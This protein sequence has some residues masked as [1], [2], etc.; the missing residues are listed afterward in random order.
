MMKQ[1]KILITVILCAFVMTLGFSQRNASGNE[2]PDFELEL[3]NGKTVR[4]SD[5]K[6]KAVLLH[7]WATWC[8]P[9]RR[10]LPEMNALAEKLEQTGNS[11]LVFLAVCVSDTE[12]NRASF[13]KQNGYTFTNG[14]D[15]A[16]TIAGKYNIS[17][18]PTSVLI[19]PSGEIEKINVGAMSKDKIDSFVKGYAD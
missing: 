9:C 14:L 2:A 13:M 11:K 1:K 16:G 6:G 10:E 7:F 17:G 4:L 15:A 19:S 5:F 12:K 3:S 8:P 18:I